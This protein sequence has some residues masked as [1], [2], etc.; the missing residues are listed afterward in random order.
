M[1]PL[2]DQCM[3]HLFI[4][5]RRPSDQEAIDAEYRYPLRNVDSYHTWLNMG[6]RGPAPHEWCRQYAYAKVASASRVG[7]STSFG[8][9]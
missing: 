5:A 2:Y 4:Y 1:E 3:K 8:V 7:G 9:R 6:G